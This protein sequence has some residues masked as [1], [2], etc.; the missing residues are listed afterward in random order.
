[1]YKN[2]TTQGLNKYIQYPEDLDP[3]EANNKKENIFQF[4]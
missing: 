1:M 3:T 4:L 2:L